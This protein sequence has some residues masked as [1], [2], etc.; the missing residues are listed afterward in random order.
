MKS[1][2]LRIMIVDDNPDC[3][4]S[5]A[6]L[7]QLDGHQTQVAYSAL[8]ALERAPQFRPALVLLDL[9]LPGVGGDEVARMRHATPATADAGLVAVTGYS[10]SEDERRTRDAGFDAHL[11]KPID[12]ACLERIISQL[13]GEPS[14]IS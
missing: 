2:P 5:L 6:S 1:A 14:S 8:S 13:P 12:L 9:G 10:R 3:A 7:L 4:D 11:V